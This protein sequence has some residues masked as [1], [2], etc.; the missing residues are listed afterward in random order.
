MGVELDEEGWPMVSDKHEDAVTHYLQ[1]MMISR[2]YY[3]GKVP[4]HVFF[5]SEK[6]WKDLCAQA[7]GDDEM[8]TPD[9][10]NYLA[11]MW[12]QLLP[13]PNKNLF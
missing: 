4:Q 8:P 11:N 7:R 6:R 5:N 2:K 1:F 3:N 9:E 12:N 10:L 13:L